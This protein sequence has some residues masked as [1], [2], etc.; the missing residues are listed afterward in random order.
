MIPKISKETLIEHRTHKFYKN[1][2]P[3]HSKP[4]IVRR[5][6]SFD[7]LVQLARNY[8]AD[9]DA[10][11]FSLSTS[12]NPREVNGTKITVKEILPKDL[13]GA[14]EDK[15]WFY[16]IKDYDDPKCVLVTVFIPPNALV[17]AY[18]VV[19]EGESDSF[20][21]PTEK[22]YILFNPWNEGRVF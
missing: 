2:D 8:E 6:L 22:V 5:G 10:F 14:I 1:L 11:Y 16:V 3:D 20:K 15:K 21:Y 4:L 18:D 7:V 12:N 9:K 13:N 19:I 17:G